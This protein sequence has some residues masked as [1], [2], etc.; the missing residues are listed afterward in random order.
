MTKNAVPLESLSDPDLLEYFL[1]WEDAMIEAFNGSKRT[2]EKGTFVP[3][4]FTSYTL[5]GKHPGFV[6]LEAYL[7]RKGLR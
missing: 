4:P 6:E 2:R 7:I 5:Y 1:R 3:S